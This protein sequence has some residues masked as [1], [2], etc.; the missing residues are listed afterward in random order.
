MLDQKTIK[1]IEEFVYLKPRSIQEIATKIKKNWRTIDR[2]IKEIES[3]YGTLSSRTF[4]EGTRGALKIIYWSSIEKISYSIFQKKL[5]NDILTLQKKEDF[6][7]FDIYQHIEDSKKKVRTEISNS[8]DSTDFEDISQAIE[9][10][11]EEIL[12]LSGNISFINLKNDKTNLFKKIDEVISKGIKIK[13]ICRV[14][15]GSEENVK[16]LLSLNHKYGKELIEIRNRKQPVRAFIIDKK[17][18]RIKEIKEPTG[19]INELSKN[20]F[21]F[22][23]IKDKDW[24]IWLSKIFWKMY[25]ESID[26]KI[27][28][29]ELE[30]ISY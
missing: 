18:F 6:S 13:V 10:A 25:T 12:I 28:I 14:S 17:F 15:I 29:K 11:K 24:T 1:E 3:T 5:E 27:R 21:I 23:T 16:R 9:S 2:Y 26:S 30:K 22:Y 8:E 4:R 20:L 7:A 19:K